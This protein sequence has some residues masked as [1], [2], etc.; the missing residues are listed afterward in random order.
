MRAEKI[1][2]RK[3]HPQLLKRNLPCRLFVLRPGELVAVD[4]LLPQTESVSVPVDDLQQLLWP[5][6]K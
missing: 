1:D 3:Q 5:V 2:A 6:S 4:F